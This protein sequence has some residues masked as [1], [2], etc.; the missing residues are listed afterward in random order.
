MKKLFTALL[1]LCL[2]GSLSA[3][4][5]GYLGKRF[6]LNVNYAAFPAIF[7]PATVRQTGNI[8]LNQQ[9][10]GELEFVAG[11][12][13][14]VVAGYRYLHMGEERGVSGYRFNNIS[15]GIKIFG[16]NSIAP[17]GT[18]HKLE[19]GVAPG[20]IVNYS[21]VNQEITKIGNV[22]GLSFIY[23]FGFN[24]ILFN[25]WVISGGMQYGLL[26]PPPLRTLNSDNV[27]S[28]NVGRTVTYMVYN[29]YLGTGVLLF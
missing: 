4:V 27:N 21:S 18:F 3:Q 20:S 22:T 6:L 17:L 9:I 16:H 24:R 12:R 5:P 1:S 29:V 14:S 8:G 15:A 28:F 25:R 7:Q 2:L 13:I 26:L 19:F 11:R 23:T 10:G